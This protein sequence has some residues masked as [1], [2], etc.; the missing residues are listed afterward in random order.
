MQYKYVELS[1]TVPAELAQQILTEQT[2]R[3]PE[4][5]Q[6]TFFPDDG[7]LVAAVN[8]QGD[9]MQDAQ[10]LTLATELTW[11]WMYDYLAGMEGSDIDDPWSMKLIDR[12]RMADYFS[13]AANPD[14]TPPSG[15]AEDDGL[16]GV[17]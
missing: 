9:G 15:P 3:V 13:R 8:I 6:V 16:A 2:A 1:Y 4:E 5:P 12:D 14:P 17:S 7:G 10:A 11:N